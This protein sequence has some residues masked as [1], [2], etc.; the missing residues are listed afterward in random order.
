[1]RRVRNMGLGPADPREA[2]LGR[3]A[4]FRSNGVL[5]GLFGREVG[6]VGGAEVGAAVAEGVDPVPASVVEALCDEVGSVG[7]AEWRDAHPATNRT[8]LAS[9]RTSVDR[10]D[11]ACIRCAIYASVF[12]AG[13]RTL[14]S[15]KDSA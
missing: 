11:T 4:G 7:E 14:K 6:G 2:V 3:R 15:G 1:M 12:L 5:A 13:S 8:T 9:V 10:I